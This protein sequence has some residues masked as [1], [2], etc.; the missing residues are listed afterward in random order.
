MRECV[1]DGVAVPAG[2]L[3]EERCGLRLDVFGVVAVEVAAKRG[4]HVVDF[5]AAEHVVLGGGFEEREYCCVD[6]R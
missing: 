4:C 1:P 6:L 3:M 2:E 5:V